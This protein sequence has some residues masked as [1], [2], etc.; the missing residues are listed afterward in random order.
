MVGI[1][2]ETSDGKSVSE[3]HNVEEECS[4]EDFSRHEV[5]IISGSGLIIGT[6]GVADG[7]KRAGDD[8]LSEDKGHGILDGLSEGKGY[9]TSG[10]GFESGLLSGTN[11]CADD[12][13]RVEDD[14]LSEDEQ[15][16]RFLP[17]GGFGTGLTDGTYALADGDRCDEDD[18]GEVSSEHRD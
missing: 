3:A 10:E 4:S 8:I 14:I 6:N 1:D 7:D 2:V 15:N 18:E 16:D 5:G 9:E 17:G 13:K 12:D 11:A